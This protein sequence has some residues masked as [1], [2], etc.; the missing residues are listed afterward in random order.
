M[1]GV[2][3]LLSALF[4]LSLL[5]P[6]LSEVDGG[7][8]K[9]C[10]AFFL[11]GV[12]PY[13]PRILEQGTV[14]KPNLKS[15]KPICQFYKNDYRFATLY[16]MNNKIPMFSA[17]KF[18]G[19]RG[20]GNNIDDTWKIEPQ[21]ENKNAIKSMAEESQGAQ[22]T[23]QAV[24]QDYKNVNT[25]P[26]V[27]RGHLFPVMHADGDDAKESTYTLTNIVPQVQTFNGGSWKLME[28]NV[29]KIM[30]QSC[31]NSNNNTEAYVVTG[32]VP[33]ENNTLNNRVNIPSFMWTAFCC[34]IST[35]QWHSGAH[36]GDNRNKSKKV[37][38]VPLSVAEL[39]NK[40][41]NMYEKRF[42]LFPKECLK[43]KESFLKQM[44][45]LAHDSACNIIRLIGDT[46]G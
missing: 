23:H 18:T 43:L 34:E 8:R 2:L 20:S 9:N 12:T 45:N 6:G 30:N 29:T 38:T 39:N 35:N 16:D 32:A 24:D 40:L 25:D 14:P 41:T 21:L 22:Y 15:Y 7:F 46:F 13:I 10:K 19:G 26:L 11:N 36:W 42:Q 37:R 31:K 33:S 5:C 27:N 28:E 1:M 44:Y 4:L 17:Y 3:K